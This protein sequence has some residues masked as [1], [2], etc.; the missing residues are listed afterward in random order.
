MAKKFEDI[1]SSI[2]EKDEH[3]KTKSYKKLSPKMKK[4]V[5]ELFNKLDTKGSNFLNNFEKA[6]SD[7][8][9]R[10]RV[11]EKQLYDYFEKEAMGI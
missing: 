4:A 2:T 7:V 1:Y 8:S 3:K 6:I 11:S 9:K 10:N 5:D